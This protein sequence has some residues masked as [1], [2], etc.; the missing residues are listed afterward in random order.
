MPYVSI[1]VAGKLTKEQKQQ[2]AQG[3]TDV[4]VKATSKP[5]EAVLLFI[6]EESPVNIAKGG[7]LIEDM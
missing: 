2:I 1:R 4:I 6:D 7:V 3:V 5:K